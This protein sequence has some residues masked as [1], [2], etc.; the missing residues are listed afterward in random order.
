MNMS[1]PAPG[2]LPTINWTRP[3]LE[4]LK[5]HHAAAVRVSLPKFEF[6]GHMFDTSYAKYLIEYLEGRLAK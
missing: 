5:D 4:R 3:K 1:T 6:D 2:A